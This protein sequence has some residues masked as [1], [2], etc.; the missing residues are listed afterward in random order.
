MTRSLV[1][2]FIG[3]I[4]IQNAWADWDKQVKKVQDKIVIIEYFEQIVSFEA[5]NEKERAKKQ[6]TGIVVNDSGL[7]MTYVC[8]TG[9]EQSPG[10][11]EQRLD[12]VLTS[13]PAGI[14]G[15]PSNPAHA[16]E[17]RSAQ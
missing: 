14:S 9:N 8:I 12:R 6:V 1:Y 13:H 5:I 17:D 3:I 4:L 7:I 11:L 2:I 16:G 10:S 15:F